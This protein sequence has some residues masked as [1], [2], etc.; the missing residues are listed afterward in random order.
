VDLE[1]VLEAKLIDLGLELKQHSVDVAKSSA[2]L[3]VQFVEV[4]GINVAE[5]VHSAFARG[6]AT[7]FTDFLV[8][9]Q[10]TSASGEKQFDGVG[11]SEIVEKFDLI[12]LLKEGF[13]LRIMEVNGVGCS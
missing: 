5:K 12:D 7:R 10:F 6:D 13:V 8:H 3:H 11:W 1:Q 4:H 9:G 2:F